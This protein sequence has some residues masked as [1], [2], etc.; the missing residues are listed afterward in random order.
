MSEILSVTVPIFILIG[1][2]YVCVMT[3]LTSRD[4]TRG[5]GVFVITIALPA[6][7]VSGMA[8]RP[9]TES[10]DMQFLGAYA[11]ASLLCFATGMLTYR[12]WRRGNIAENSMFGLGMSSSNT[13]FIGVS[14]CAMVLGTELASRAVAM[15]IIVES[16]LMIPGAMAIADA[17]NTHTGVHPWARIKRTIK[18][19]SRSPL[20][21]AICIGLFLSGFQ[22]RLPQVVASVSI[23]W[24]CRCPG[25]LVCGGRKFI[26]LAAKRHDE[27]CGRDCSGEAGAAPRSHGIILF[28]VAGPGSRAE[29]SRAD[30][31]ASPMLSIFPII[32][33]RYGL[34]DRCSTAL[35]IGTA[36]SFVTV[37]IT[38]ALIT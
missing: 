5:L 16:M 36:A 28:D 1:L 32:G 10:M 4:T 13:G 33:M 29:A 37:S 35:L 15:A 3:G 8:S 31:A 17:A 11:G 23:C 9:L 25:G 27:G 34:E 26:W 18:Q 30:F 7:I 14:I 20:L 12:Y 22:I 24:S 21:I 2:G 19:L 6:V 38:I